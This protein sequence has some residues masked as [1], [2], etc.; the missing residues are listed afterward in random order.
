MTVH[1]KRVMTLVRINTYTAYTSNILETREELER[2]KQSF[3]RDEEEM[4][5]PVDPPSNDVTIVVSNQR[6][7]IEKITEK[8][9]DVMW[10]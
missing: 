6:T 1:S 8:M 9:V 7:M 3:E 4:T 10:H 2:D 5:Q